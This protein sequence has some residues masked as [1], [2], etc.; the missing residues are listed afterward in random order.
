MVD[1]QALTPFQAGR[2]LVESFPYLPDVIALVR[3]LA[4]EWSAPSAEELLKAGAMCYAER[5]GAADIKVNIHAVQR[6]LP[7]GRNRNNL[8]CWG[9]SCICH[10]NSCFKDSICAFAATYEHFCTAQ[11]SC[12]P[13]VPVVDKVGDLV[14]KVKL[15]EDSPMASK[16]S[17]ESSRGL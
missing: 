3:E 14:K 1:S 8:L 11:V 12:E 9:R 4:N 13:Y 6:V 16:G 7:A 17:N 10:T 2:M 15:W 5:Q